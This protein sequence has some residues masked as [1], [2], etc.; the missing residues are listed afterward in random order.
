MLSHAIPSFSLFGLSSPLL[1][2]PLFFAFRRG[3]LDR[4]SSPRMRYLRAREVHI[5]HYTLAV[6]FYVL[7]LGIETSFYNYIYFVS[8]L[9]F[10]HIVHFLFRFILFQVSHIASQDIRYLCSKR[11]IEIE[12]FLNFH[13]FFSSLSNTI[14]KNLPISYFNLFF[15][16]DQ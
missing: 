11:K 7:D 16:L 13:F 4:H 6:L 1:S 8:S 2:S 14:H 3:S 5:F 10:I 9:F 15:H 12:K